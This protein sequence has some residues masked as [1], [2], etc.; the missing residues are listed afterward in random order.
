[1]RMYPQLDTRY[2]MPVCQSVNHIYLLPPSPFE[3]RK[4]PFRVI[5]NAEGK[6]RG[7]QV[8]PNAIKILA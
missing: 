7:Q 6:K 2:Q 4:Y 8:S 5:L 1:M 3:K